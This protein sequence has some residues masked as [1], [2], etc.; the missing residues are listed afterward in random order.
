MRLHWR[1]YILLLFLSYKTWFTYSQYMFEC[2][3]NYFKIRKIRFIVSHKTHMCTHIHTETHACV[4]TCV[5]TQFKQ[6]PSKQLFEL[7]L[8][9]ILK[10][11]IFGVYSVWHLSTS[12]KC[13][14]SLWLHLPILQVWWS[15]SAFRC[16]LIKIYWLN[17]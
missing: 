15:L 13:E 5:P 4:C 1:A 2:Y 9:N 17:I 10:C 3:S 14:P 7:T 6:Q 16:Y 12:Q 11:F 8:Y